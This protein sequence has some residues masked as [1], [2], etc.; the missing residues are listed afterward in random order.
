MSI[1]K[2]IVLLSVAVSL[3]VAF[4]PPVD[5]AGPLTAKIEGPAKITQTT[6]PEPFSVVLENSADAAIQGTVRAEGIDGW[7]VQ[8]GGGM[9][10]SVAGKS[11]AREIEVVDKD[12]RVLRSVPVHIVNGEVLLTSEPEVFSYRL[13]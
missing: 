11:S 5:T 8:P 6:N 12:G 9:P 2:T 4:H 3:L 7:R 1:R 13:H 10:F